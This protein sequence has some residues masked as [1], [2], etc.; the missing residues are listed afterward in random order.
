[1]RPS[2]IRAVPQT[3]EELARDFHETVEES[4]RNMTPAKARAFL[5]RAGIAEKCK[6][7]PS[8][9]RLVKQLRTPRGAGVPRAAERAGEGRATITNAAE[10]QDALRELRTL[11]RR[12]ARLLRAH[13]PGANG[14]V[15]AGVRKT[16]AR[17]HE[18]LAVYEG[19]EEA[20][21]F[22]PS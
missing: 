21:R 4:N 19:G 13:A 20:W 15:K 6:S 2:I 16:I 8:G 1:L 5:I 9:I 3:V 11:E 7:S 18:A 12:L 14:L 22:E 10:Y 17:L